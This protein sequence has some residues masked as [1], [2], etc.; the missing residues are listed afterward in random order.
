MLSNTVYLEPLLQHDQNCIPIA[1]AVYIE[2]WV[3]VA[4][5]VRGQVFSLSPLRLVLQMMSPPAPAVEA[6]IENILLLK[7]A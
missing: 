1:A 2:Q 7:I 6:T 3:L 4:L 5:C